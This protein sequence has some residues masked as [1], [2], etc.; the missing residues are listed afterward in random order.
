MTKGVVL[1]FILDELSMDT[2]RA[3]DTLCEEKK[4]QHKL[5]MVLIDKPNRLKLAM[6]AKTRMV[7][8]DNDFINRL[9]KL[10]VSYKIER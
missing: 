10:G 4:G 2:V 1:K 5:R 8:A 3:L 9:D 7:H 6:A